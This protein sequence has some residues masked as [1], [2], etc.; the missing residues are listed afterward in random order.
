[1]TFIA[2][3]L[4]LCSEPAIVHPKERP[5]CLQTI[6]AGDAFLLASPTD[7][8]IYSLHERKKTTPASTLKILTALVSLECLGPRYRFPTEFYLDDHQ[9][10][11]VKG[12]G[13][14][15]LVSE[16]WQ[17]IAQ[18]LAEKIRSFKHL[19]LD[20][21]YF[22]P[23]IR[24]PGCGYST[25]PYDAPVG[26]LCANF[27][28]CLFRTDRRGRICSAEP[29]TPMVPFAAKRIRSLKERNG[30]C[31]LT[32]DPGEAARYAGELL[33]HFLKERG[34]R[35]DGCVRP[36]LVHSEDKRIHVYYSQFTVTDVLQ[37]MM[38]FS[39]NF[40]ANQLFISVGAHI[41]GPPATLAKAVHVV[42]TYVRGELGLEGVEIVE[43]SGISRRN[44]LSAFHMYTLLKRF[45]SHRRLLQREEELLYKTGTL[46]G[47]RTRAGYVQKNPHEV[48]PFVIF[49]KRG[50][51]RV[52]LLMECTRQAVAEQAGVP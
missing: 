39:N 32:Y 45:K 26:A 23:Q 37:K 17:R 13:D 44:R 31:T 50:G 29:Q 9:N 30:R 47:V 35:H 6:R 16:T 19:I 49:L 41:H 3:V 38:E 42:S 43:G 40:I 24:I 52:D 21:S 25:N 28:T 27:N 15:L 34:I 36:G 7:Q 33:L 22:S 2:V 12:Y 5:D 8:I 51:S 11:K 10:L 1:M 14:P 46:K 4:V 18:A 48:Y 20:T